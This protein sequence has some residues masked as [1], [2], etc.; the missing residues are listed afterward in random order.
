[1]FAALLAETIQSFF[2]A[3]ASKLVKKAH[4]FSYIFGQMVKN[5]LRYVEKVTFLTL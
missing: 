1:M 5:I 2:P 4:I 3:L